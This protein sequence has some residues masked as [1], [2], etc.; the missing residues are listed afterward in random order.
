MS[1]NSN[2][3]LTVGDNRV[4]LLL[5]FTQSADI[6]KDNLSFFESLCTFRDANPDCVN[7]GEGGISVINDFDGII[8]SGND[9]ETV[10]Y[11][12]VDSDLNMYGNYTE[13]EMANRKMELDECKDEVQ[14]IIND[15]IEMWDFIA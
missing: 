15:A 13:E 10:S 12:I 14:K 4:E 7:H 2:I 11:F 3:N 8:H 6:V 5:G 9:A 1:R